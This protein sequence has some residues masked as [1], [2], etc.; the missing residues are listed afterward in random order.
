MT[1]EIDPAKDFSP[2]MFLLTRW[3]VRVCIVASAFALYY[4]W[5]IDYQPL[6]G[7]VARAVGDR[8]HNPYADGN[9]YCY[10]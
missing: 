8:P 4:I 6:C 5:Q 7:D 3:F 9:D 10:D 2:V 1:K